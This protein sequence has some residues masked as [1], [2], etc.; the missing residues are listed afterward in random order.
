M[1]F[2]VSVRHQSLLLTYWIKAEKD[3]IFIAFRQKKDLLIGKIFLIRGPHKWFGD[4]NDK[5]LIKKL[6]NKIDAV[7]AQNFVSP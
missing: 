5:Q 2:K 7:M 3:E 1:T 6:G 4:V